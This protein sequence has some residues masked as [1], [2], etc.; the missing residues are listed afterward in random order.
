MLAVDSIIGSDIFLFH[1]NN[2][3]HITASVIIRQSNGKHLTQQESVQ[4]SCPKRSACKGNN[5]VQCTYGCVEERKS[6]AR[7]YAQEAMWRPVQME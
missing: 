2:I 7:T 3:E 4:S 5:I 6:L 1:N